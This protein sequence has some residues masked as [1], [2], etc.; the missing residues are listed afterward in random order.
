MTFFRCQVGPERAGSDC[1]NE[2]YTSYVNGDVM[3]RVELGSDSVFRAATSASRCCEICSLVSGCLYWMFEQHYKRVAPR[4]TLMRG[5]EGPALMKTKDDLWCPYKNFELDPATWQVAKCETADEAIM[6]PGYISG[7]PPL[8]RATKGKVSIAVDVSEVVL[9]PENNYTASYKIRVVG[10][11]AGRGAVWVMPKFN[12]SLSIV[13]APVLVFYSGRDVEQEVAVKVESGSLAHGRH[14]VEH[15]VKACDTAFA[16]LSRTT[17]LRLS[18]V[19]VPDTCAPGSYRLAEFTMCTLCPPG[20]FCAGGAAPAVTPRA[21]PASTFNQVRGST[22]NSSCLPCEVGTFTESDGQATCEPCAHGRFAISKGTAQ[23]KPCDFGSY[24]GEAGQSECTA[25][26]MVDSTTVSRGAT[27]PSECVCGQG[28]FAPLSQD[29]CLQCPEGLQCEVGSSLSTGAAVP[30]VVAGYY[31]EFKNASEGASISVYVCEPAAA[32]PGGKLAEEQSC[33]DRRT[34][35]LC[36]QCPK[37]THAAGAGCKDCGGG[38]YAVIAILAL[39]LLALFLLVT[40]VWGKMH[41]AAASPHCSAGLKTLALALMFFQ[42]L[43]AIYNIGIAWEDPF[44]AVVAAMTLLNFDI[45]IIHIGCMQVGG[46]VSIYILK[47]VLPLVGIAVMFTTWF[48]LRVL[49]IGNLSFDGVLNGVGSVLTIFYITQTGAAFSPY[50]CFPH[51][52]GKLSMTWAPQVLCNDDSRHSSMVGVSVFGIL[53]YPVTVFAVTAFAVWRYPYEIIGSN[54]RFVTRFGFIFHRWAPE[55]YWFGLVILVRNFL[56]AALP[57]LIPKSDYKLAILLVEFV[58]LMMACMLM[59]YWPWKL[60]ILTSCDAGLNLGLLM[61]LAVA[62]VEHVSTTYSIVCT[63]LFAGLTLSTGVLLF[64]CA[65]QYVRGPTYDVFVSHHK[66]DAACGARLLKLSLSTKFTGGIF[67]DCDNLTFLGALFDQV[68]Q[69]KIVVVILSGAVLS[70]P[71]CLGEIAQAFLSK[72]KMFPV[73]FTQKGSISLGND[74]SSKTEDEIAKLDGIATLCPFGISTSAIEKGIAEL[75]SGLLWHVPLD[76]TSGFEGAVRGMC[77]E[78]SALMSQSIRA[79]ISGIMTPRVSKTAVPT[80][81]TEEPKTWLLTNHESKE[82]LAAA[83]VIK[84]LF[85][86]LAQLEVALDIGYSVPSFLAAIKSGPPKGDRPSVL[87]TLTEGTLTNA[88]QMVRGVLLRR[89]RQAYF[90]PVIVG[91]SFVFPA[92]DFFKTFSTPGGPFGATAT[93]DLSEAAG[94]VVKPEDVAATLQSIFA[95]LAVV[96]NVP[97]ASEAMLKQSM[98]TMI[99]RIASQGARKDAAGGAAN[100]TPTSGANSAVVANQAAPPTPNAAG[101]ELPAASSAVAAAPAEDQA[102][103]VISLL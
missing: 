90:T 58:L 23:C 32:C 76:S 29:R 88:K 50:S 72:I 3:M 94:E 40:V 96:V 87:W 70:R 25:C 91:D 12:I 56:V 24:Q 95:N 26:R 61:L 7:S 75:L 35:F 49:N 5:Y 45:D 66:K 38:S 34:G 64:R 19:V 80:A 1:E 47:M 89:Y 59:V 31:V 33:G 8:T 60:S 41:P 55:R 93:A 62:S 14:V 85:Q 39:L 15:E 4:C 78:L 30:H 68:K 17:P 73:T 83:R 28:S 42:T 18:V 11:V 57:I 67:L 21:C 52:N 74:A 2:M 46:P 101:K 69:S 79:Q 98:S 77:G 82:A 10:M 92:E 71:W 9:R 99:L 81:D 36:T 20:F 51:P 37:G 22:S 48:T 100:A 97:G 13:T 43:G 54:L 6:G 102:A 63:V 27:S 65:L 103:R 44:K 53:A 84:F 86:K 16:L